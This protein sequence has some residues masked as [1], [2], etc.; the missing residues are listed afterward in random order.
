MVKNHQAQKNIYIEIDCKVKN[1]L[2]EQLWYYRSHR[3]TIPDCE[4]IAVLAGLHDYLQ[5]LKK[6]MDQNL[7]FNGR[8][9]L[10]WIADHFPLFCQKTGWI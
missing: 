4:C 9:C 6:Q 5:L 2:D 7:S 10:H 8:F 3:N 1:Y